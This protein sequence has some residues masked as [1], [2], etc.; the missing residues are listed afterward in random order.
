MPKHPFAALTTLLPFTLALACACSGNSPNTAGGVHDAAVVDTGTVAR[1]L[2]AGHDVAIRHDAHVAPAVDASDAPAAAVDAPVDVNNGAPS[3]V[4]PAPHP[5]LPQLTNYM[6][7]PV[8]KT[9]TVYLIFYPGYPYVMDMQTFATNMTKATYWGTV[10]SEYGVG[11]LAYA[12]TITLT[13]QT[14]PE[15]ITS[16][17]IESWMGQQIAS[18]AFGTPD[19]QG[20]YTIFYPET[21]TVTQPNPVLPSLGAVQSCVAFGAYHDNVAVPLTDGG[22]PTEFSYAVIPT[23]G[24]NPNDLTAV[25]SHEWVEASTDPFLT[26]GGTFNLTGGPDSAYFTVDKDHAIWAVLGGGEAGDLCEPEGASNPNFIYL[27]PPDV[28]YLVQRIWSNA[29]ASASHDPCIPN[30]PGANFNAAPVLTDTV[31]ISSTLIG[32]TLVTQGVIIPAATSATI[33]IDL[34]SDSATSG[35]ITVT[36]ADAIST[37]YG[38]YAPPGTTLLEPSL[39]FSWDRSSGVNGDILHLTITV[40]RQE[41]LLDG[42]HVFMLTSTVAGS[43]KQAVWVGLVAEYAGGGVDAGD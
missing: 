12:S 35:P 28:G 41:E 1:H 19:P 16:L 9:P 31:T 11:P 23:C 30:L 13:G 21:T 10:T 8:L 36:A 33:P 25:I 34:F 3:T 7:G 40:T 20:I 29:S 38:S 6:G 27:T 42:L 5:P 37:Y 18:G 24:T 17:E 2:D 4:Y 14:P 39:A 32:G 26:S 15:T 43:N 22:K